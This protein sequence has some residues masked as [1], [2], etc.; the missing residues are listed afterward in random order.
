MQG[1]AV[2][3][4]GDVVQIAVFFDADGEETTERETAIAAVAE[5]PDGKWAVINLALFESIT[6]H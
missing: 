3:D 4:D 6:V 5:L 1:L 2:T